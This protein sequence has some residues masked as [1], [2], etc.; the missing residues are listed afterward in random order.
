MLNALLVLNA[1]LWETLRLNRP[2]LGIMMHVVP[3]GGAHIA[4]AATQLPVGKGVATQAYTLQRSADLF[5]QLDEWQLARWLTS[6]KVLSV[7][8]MSSGLLSQLVA[9]DG[10]E[11][12]ASSGASGVDGNDD[13]TVRALRIFESEAMREHMLIFSM[14]TRANPGQPIALM[15]LKLSA[16]ALAQHFVMLRLGDK[17]QTDEDMRQVNNWLLAPIGKRCELVFD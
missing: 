6:A 3:H 16:A 8:L 11:A 10:D 15:E 13:D 7:P 5:P 14:G 9:A 17:R 1:V 2:M 4:S 12:K